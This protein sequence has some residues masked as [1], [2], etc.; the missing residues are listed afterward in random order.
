LRLTGKPLSAQKIL[1][2]G[3]GEAGTGI[4]D[5]IVSAMVDE[6]A[7]VGEARARCWF[8]DSKGLVVKSRGDLAEH[9]LRYAH[10]GE[11]ITSFCEAIRALSPSAIV[12][13]STVPGSFDRAV[14]EEMARLNERPI[15]FA[16]SNPTSRSECT[17]EQAYAW[18]G[19]RAIFASG[20]PFPPV[21][22]GDRVLVPGQ[23]NNAYIFPGVGLGV[24]ACEARRV[25]DRMFA[26]AARALA[27]ETTEADLA[28]GRVYPS[29]GRIREVSA[30]IAAAVADVAF[31]D[32]LAGVPRPDDLAALVQANVWEP[33]YRRYLDP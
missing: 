18:S 6:G 1:F 12:G 14:I 23:G 13:V 16:L 19:G 3:A 27:D 30:R 11:G 21:T 4:A 17:A 32:G 8:V 15:V 31:S 20:S 2:L 9:K 28:M 29:L 26:T 10:E 33:R 7:A 5:L 22:L 24:V 25:T